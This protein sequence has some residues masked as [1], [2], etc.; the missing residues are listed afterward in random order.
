MNFGYILN[1]KDWSLYNGLILSVNYYI[2]F[3]HMKKKD[4]TP[5]KVGQKVKGSNGIAKN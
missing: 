5:P 4:T 3:H 2:L 1:M